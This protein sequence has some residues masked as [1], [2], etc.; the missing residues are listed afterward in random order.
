M[1]NDAMAYKMHYVPD[2]VHTFL[3]KQDNALCFS[4]LFI[5]LSIIQW[6]GSWMQ[7]IDWQSIL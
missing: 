1:D 2:P 5:P 3:F 4:M 6:Q 7:I